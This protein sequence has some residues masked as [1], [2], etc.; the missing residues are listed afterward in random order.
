MDLSSIVS[1]PLCAQILGDL[2][3]DVVKVEPPGGD[4]A[5]YLGAEGQPAMAGI[6][7]QVNRNK[8]SIA[9]DLKR[10]ADRE[11]F[12]KLAASADVVVENFRPGVSDRLGIGFEVARARNPG[13]IW[14]AISGFGPEGP[15]A[16]QP[17]YDMIIQGMSG[18]ARM[19]GDDQNPRL[20][21]NLVADKTSGMTACYSVIAALY[22]REKSG[23]QG[24]RLDVPMID[25]FASFL[26]CDGFAP[27]TYGGAPR[28]RAIE[29]RST[30]RARASAE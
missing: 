9:L 10:E 5:R 6:F 17:A 14:V 21:G 20:I 15:Y 13:L 4:T 30:T 16:D 12:L 29:E 7:V 11:A 3:A 25:A 28:D 26:L 24:Q 19:L 1:G 23:G 22:A 18:F 27:Q 8:R 2:G